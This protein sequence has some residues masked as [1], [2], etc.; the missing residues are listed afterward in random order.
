MLYIGGWGHE[1]ADGSAAYT[2]NITAFSGWDFAEE[3]RDV[4]AAYDRGWSV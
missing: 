2:D 3:M 1:Q 4:Q